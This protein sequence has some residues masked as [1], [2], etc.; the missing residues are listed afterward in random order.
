MFAQGWGDQRE[1]GVQISVICGLLICT[2]WLLHL[3]NKHCGWRVHAELLCDW[4]SKAAPLKHKAFRSY[5]AHQAAAAL[6][7][8]VSGM[9]AVFHK[10]P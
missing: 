8:Q 5:H 3:N 9:M 4:R 10:L 2:Q 1:A 7:A 6:H